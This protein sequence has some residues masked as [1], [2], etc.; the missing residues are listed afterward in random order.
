MS[1][2]FVKSQAFVRPQ[3]PCFESNSQPILKIGFASSHEAWHSAGL[4]LSHGV[5]AHDD[6]H[7]CPERRAQANFLLALGRCVGGIGTDD[8]L[9]DGVCVGWCVGRSV[10]AL[11]G[12]ADGNIDGI[13]VGPTLGLSVRT[14]DGTALGDADSTER[15]HCA[16]HIMPPPIFSIRHFFV[17]PH[18]PCASSYSQPRPSKLSSF[19]HFERHSAGSRT[20]QGCSNHDDRQEYPLFN[21]QTFRTTPT[22]L[23]GS[24]VGV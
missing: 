9:V 7:A 20:A 12:Y 1:F 17:R 11:L 24:H 18:V 14:S 23:A 4:L 2:K 22:F 19:S 3:V 5:V 8:G 15:E 21:S 6:I 10:G 13:S 16:P